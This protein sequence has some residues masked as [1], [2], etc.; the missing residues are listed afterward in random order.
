MFTKKLKVYLYSKKKK[1]DSYQHSKKVVSEI[2]GLEDF[3]TIR[4]VSSLF[5]THRWEEKCY[6]EFKLQK[7]LQSILL[8]KMFFWAN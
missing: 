1:V 6:W 7:N 5:L 8:I 3:A 2:P 4:L